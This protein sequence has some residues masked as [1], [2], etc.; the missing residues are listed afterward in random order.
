MWEN[1]IEAKSA[2]YKVKTNP[3]AST[4]SLNAYVWNHLLK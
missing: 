4:I 3:N 2:D 1:K